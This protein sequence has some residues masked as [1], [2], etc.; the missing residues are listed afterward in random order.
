MND[1]LDNSPEPSD[2]RS[3]QSM[4][5]IPDQEKN[6]PVWQ[7]LGN[8]S[9]KE[10]SDFFARNIIR[11]TRALAQPTLATRLQSLFTPKRLL[12]V[13][14]SCLLI[15]LGIQLWSTDQPAQT[16]AATAEDIYTEPSLTLGE[17]IIEENLNAA[18]ED[19]SIYTRDEIVAMIGF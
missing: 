2:I 14:C 9:K 3:R 15:I 1:H 18:A 7:L 16:T 11:E 12:A 19:P 13:S 17:L 8:A 6:D 10:P 5:E 4:P